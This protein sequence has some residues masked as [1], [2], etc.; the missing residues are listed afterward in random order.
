MCV[1]V[2]YFK[3]SFI[4]WFVY[5]S[6]E[7]FYTI[8]FILFFIYHSS[9]LLFV[10]L[11]LSYISFSSFLH[12]LIYI[13]IYGSLV[14]CSPMVQ[15][16]GV[17]SQVESYQRLK[18]WYFIPLALILGVIRYGSRVKWINSGKGVALS[19][20]VAIEKGAF[21]SHST[22]VTDFTYIRVCVCVCV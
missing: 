6:V 19:P 11:F 15:E 1:S 13:Y 10:S 3:K 9:P 14:Y 4:Y 5:I 17:Q 21:G 2:S 12:L 7:L 18:K 8:S 16:T 20:I 22:T